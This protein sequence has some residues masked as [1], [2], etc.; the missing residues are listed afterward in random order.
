MV[1]DGRSASAGTVAVEGSF[2]P[3]ERVVFQTFFGMI[4]T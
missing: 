1:D 3:A 4:F 2:D